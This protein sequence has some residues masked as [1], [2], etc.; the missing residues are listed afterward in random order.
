M[1]IIQGESAFYVKRMRRFFLIIL[2]G[3]LLTSFDYGTELKQVNCWKYEQK[4]WG[5]ITGSFL[6]P[7]GDLILTFKRGPVIF[8][9]SRSVPFAPFGQGPDEVTRLFTICSYR[10]NLALF[11]DVNKIKVFK[12]AR[13]TYVWKQTMWLKRDPWPLFLKA[14]LFCHGH[15]FL[16]GMNILDIPKSEGNIRISN[17]QIF[18]ESSKS[19]GKNIVLETGVHADRHYEIDRF[20][21]PYG[22]YVLYFKQNEMKIHFISL[23]KMEEEKSV[24]LHTPGFYKPMP[25]DFYVRKDYQ[26]NHKEYLMDLDEWATSYSAITKVVVYQNSHLILQI[27]TH[28]EPQGKFALLFYDLNRN[29]ALEKTIFLNDLLLAERNGCLYCY[30]NGNPDLDEAADKTEIII[31][32]IVH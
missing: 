20:L 24:D 13:S 25:H 32:K 11:E 8:G 17:L 18:E 5:P 31:Y 22:A 10:E 30:K 7:A 15:F 9:E 23:D 12:K 21:I 27:R 2:S 16:A 4:Y 26:G 28:A 19:S 14:A 29:C 3:T 1:I 6:D